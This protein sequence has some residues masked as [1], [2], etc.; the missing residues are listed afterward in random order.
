MLCIQGLPFLKLDWSKLLR[1]KEQEG[2]KT[3]KQAKEHK[4]TN[5]TFFLS[6]GEQTGIC[7]YCL[8]FCLS[9][10]LGLFVVTAGA[11]LGDLHDFSTH[12]ICF[13]SPLFAG[14]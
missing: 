8:S 1:S 12:G 6:V 4:K 14:C 3:N 11:S 5:C 13:D 7:K 9:D 2:K 10:Q